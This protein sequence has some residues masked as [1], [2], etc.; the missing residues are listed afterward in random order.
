MKNKTHNEQ[1]K[2]KAEQKLADKKDKSDDK[3][4]WHPAFASTMR[5]ELAEYK[6]MLSFLS[7][8]ELS[9]KPL[10]MDVLIIKKQKDLEIK[11]NIGR[12]FR[13]HNIIEYKSPR[14]YL[15]DD[16]FYKAYAYACLYKILAGK[17]AK[18]SIKDITIT[19]VSSKYPQHMCEYLKNEGYEI[20]RQEQGIYYIEGDRIPIQ[21]VVTSELEEEN[22]LWLY[23]LTDNLK[24]KATAE[25]IL[26]TCQGHLK[27]DDY[28]SYVDVVMRANLDVFMEVLRM[29]KLDES[30]LEI[31]YEKG[32]VKKLEQIG[33]EKG[34]EKG[35]VLG[36]V[37]MLIKLNHDKEDIVKT[38]TTDYC[39]DKDEAEKIIEEVQQRLNKAS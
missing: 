12:I 37:E 4:Q 13:E 9:K 28:Q 31:M 5:I 36:V 18:T 21:I 38:I 11:K 24:D 39:I 29:N 34:L 10:R 22:N 14:D 25:K 32:F 8:F 27:D 17:T 6:E 16:D 1:D 33:M 26:T 2:K 19:F 3:I 23:S 20:N 30:L 35:R 7:E 15:S